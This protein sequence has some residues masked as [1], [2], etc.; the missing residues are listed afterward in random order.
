MQTI[1]FHADD[2]ERFK[3]LGWVGENNQGR[4]ERFGMSTEKAPPS[5]LAFAES[6]SAEEFEHVVSQVNRARETI[7]MQVIYMNENLTEDDLSKVRTIFAK[8]NTEKASPG[9]KI[10]T[11]AGN[12]VIK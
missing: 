2:L 4:V 1:D 11:D 7:M 12:W 3:R 9:D 8:I 5:L 6:Y 10:Q